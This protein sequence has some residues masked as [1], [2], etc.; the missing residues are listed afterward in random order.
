MKLWSEIIET[1]KMAREIRRRGMLSLW[2]EHKDRSSYVET[3]AT[4]GK[5]AKLALRDPITRYDLQADEANSNVKVAVRAIS[6]AIRSLPVR[7]KVVTV[8]DGK[9]IEED[10]SDSSLAAWIERPNSEHDISELM[11]HTTKCFLLD[12]NSYTTI[13][14][15]T[16]P[17]PGVETWPRDPR[18]VQVIITENGQHGG[19]RIGLGPQEARN[20]KRDRLI[21]VRDIDPNRP[22]YGE[23][24]IQGIRDEIALDHYVNQFNSGFFKSGCLINAMFTPDKELSPTQHKQI[25]DALK[26]DLQGVD[27]MWSLFIN[28]YPGKIESPEIKHKE[29]AF[30]NLLRMNREKIYSAFG[31]PPFRGGVME[32]ANYANAIEQDKDFW[33]NTIKAILQVIEIC[34]NR[35]LIRP[36]LGED[37]RMRFDMS[38][39]PALKGNPKEQAEIIDILVNADVIDTDEARERLDM[40]KRETSPETPIGKVLIKERRQRRTTALAALHK[41]THGGRETWWL[42]GSEI[43]ARKLYDV[44][45]YNVTDATGSLAFRQAIYEKCRE[46]GNGSAPDSYAAIDG[47]PALPLLVRSVQEHNRQTFENVRSLLAAAS[48]NKAPY[49]EI[50]RQL[51]IV[52]SDDISREIMRFVS[53]QIERAAKAILETKAGRS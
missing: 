32:Y 6:D 20:Y 19:Y 39:V 50:Q 26:A 21:H 27:R 49:P 31:L 53:A 41:L 33:N 43:Q 3:W 48:A 18:Q 8:E 22:F 17:F 42:D 11:S 9:E 52:M 7:A 25:M 16:G 36:L 23:S 15:N 37:L 44:E 47:G 10:A 5:G 2:Q 13:E 45:Q 30:E 29:I 46:L 24:R 14:T 40:P 4:Y 35:W 38:D 12:G 28:R 51:R 34:F 1:L